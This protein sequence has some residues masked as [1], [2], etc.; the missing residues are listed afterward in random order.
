MAVKNK[1]PT[2]EIV[3]DD[4]KRREFVTG[5]RRRRNERRQKARKKIAEQ[6]RSDKIAARKERAEHMKEIRSIGVG[7]GIDDGSSDED[8]NDDDDAPQETLLESNTYEFQG[9]LAT[10]V[11][12]TLL[13]EPEVGLPTPPVALLGGGA[14][15]RKGD[16][17][18]KP[19]LLSRRIPLDVPLANAIPGYK[20]PQSA[21]KKKK[22]KPKKRAGSRDKAS[23][24]AAGGPTGK[25]PRKRKR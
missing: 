17:E 25:P 6:V 21:V 18:P 20:P 10:A 16:S 2:A 4:E 7:A 23:G 11:V 12:T 9:G 1:R 13:D 3:F 24:K 8:D 14:A 19:K 5:F 22:K 15:R